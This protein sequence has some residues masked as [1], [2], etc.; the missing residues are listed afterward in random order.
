[1]KIQR[2]VVADRRRP[3]AGWIEAAALAG[4]L[5]RSAAVT[6]SYYAAAA[7]AA[8]AVLTEL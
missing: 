7:A 4:W 5:E 1:L 2:R 6:R 8:A 3:R